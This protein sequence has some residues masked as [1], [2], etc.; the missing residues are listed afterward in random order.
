MDK[1]G[2]IGVMNEKTPP[3]T[4]NSKTTFWRLCN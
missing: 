3:I 4:G 2:Y 1:Y